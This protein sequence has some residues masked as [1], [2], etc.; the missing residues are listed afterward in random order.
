MGFICDE[1]Q[2]RFAGPSDYSECKRGLQQLHSYSVVHGDLN[3]FNIIIIPDD[4]RFI[5]LEKS[6]LDV[7]E[8]ISKEE[9][10]HLQQEE[11]DRLEKS[12][13]DEGW[14]NPDQK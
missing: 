2:G 8:N 9:F 6:V 7:D 13:H 12:L 1:L 11:L 4:P 14:G 3:K 10:A 5:D